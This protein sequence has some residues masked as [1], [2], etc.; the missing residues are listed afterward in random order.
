M[1]IGYSYC[2]RLQRI[3]SIAPFPLPGLSELRDKYTYNIAP[4]MEMQGTKKSINF[5]K[6][7][8]TDDDDDDEE[9]RI[10]LAA[11]FSSMFPLLRSKGV[12]NCS[13]PSYVRTKSAQMT[14]YELSHY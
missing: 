9:S 5:R 13:T 12:E 7:L 6:V 14:K 8:K 4:W 10:A 2:C 1:Y 3:V 11:V